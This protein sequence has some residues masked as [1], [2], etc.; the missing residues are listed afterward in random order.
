MTS[1]SELMET[2]EYGPSVEDSAA[3]RD[4]LATRGA[5]GHFIGG[6]F[7]EPGAL[8][9]TRDP[10]TDEVLAQVTQGTA[11]DVAAAVAAA[12]RALRRPCP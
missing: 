12:V 5:L 2:L 3:V 9:D 6:S 10:A 7:T 4:W 11:E 8:F 1:V